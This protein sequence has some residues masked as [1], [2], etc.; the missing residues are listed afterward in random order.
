MVSLST[1]VA[2][3]HSPMKSTWRSSVICQPFQYHTMF[4][5]T[6]R[7]THWGNWLFITWHRLVNL[8]GSFSW[9]LLGKESRYSEGCGHQWEGF[10]PRRRGR[11]VVWSWSKLVIKR[12][13]KKS[14]GSSRPLLWG[15]LTC[16]NM[17]REQIKQTSSLS[18]IYL[19]IF[20]LS[21][22][23]SLILRS[24]N[25]PMNQFSPKLHRTSPSSLIYI[26]FSSSFS[27]IISVHRRPFSQRFAIPTCKLWTW[28]IWLLIA[29]SSRHAQTQ[30]ISPFTRISPGYI[31]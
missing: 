16:G 4:G 8:W 23:V 11:N 24:W 19:F 14:F 28:T 20:S 18:S 6:K 30:G 15:I 1:L 3:L 25:T 27:F 17:C 7:R 29:I 9:S 5:L 31:R 2:F 12:S 22:I 13:S 26:P 10:L 21:L